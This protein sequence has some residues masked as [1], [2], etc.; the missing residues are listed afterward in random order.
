MISDTQ[1]LSAED[2]RKYLQRICEEA[3]G[4]MRDYDP[5]MILEWT[6]TNVADGTC[7][8]VDVRI[9]KDGAH[10][11]SIAMT[12]EK[13]DI[14]QLGGMFG[15][16][17]G[18]EGIADY[19]LDMNLRDVVTHGTD[20]A[21]AKVTWREHIIVQAPAREGQESRSRLTAEAEVDCVHLLVREE[22]RLA[23]GMTLCS[24][25]IRLSVSG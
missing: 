1:G 7:F 17:A 18:K 15:A 22:G 13:E 3:E 16:A 19:S 25:T 6:D 24:G 12:L 2:V 8:Q 11:G 23:L 9:Q 21:T 14:L 4:L 10:T 20:A 5:R